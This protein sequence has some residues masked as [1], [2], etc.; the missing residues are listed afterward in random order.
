MQSYADSP[1]WPRFLFVGESSVPKYVLR[2]L[3]FVSPCTLVQGPQ[4]VS[5]SRVGLALELGYLP[6]ST[7]KSRSWHSCLHH[8][9]AHTQTS[10]AHS[11]EWHLAITA[12]ASFCPITIDRP[13]GTHVSMWYIIDVWGEPSRLWPEVRMTTTKEHKVGWLNVC[14]FVSSKHKLIDVARCALCAKG[15]PFRVATRRYSG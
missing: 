9:P 5:V 14:F 2:K 11:Q 13:T 12:C 6:L 8:Q 1:D 4:A 3:G 10:S 15:C 7:F